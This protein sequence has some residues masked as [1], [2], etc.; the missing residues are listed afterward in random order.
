[1]AAAPKQ[2][3]PLVKGRLLGPDRVQSERIAQLIRDLD[4]LK[5]ATRENA[6][7]ELA[8]FDEFAFPQLFQALNGNP[9]AEVRERITSL[10]ARLKPEHV[11]LRVDRA[12]EALERSGAAEA[13]SAL[14]DLGKGASE[15]GVRSKAEAAVRRVRERGQS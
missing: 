14:E 1:M 8:A 12:L 6:Q 10:V 15:K 9:A 4:S 2:T 5:F 11:Q 7:K 3:A 13:V